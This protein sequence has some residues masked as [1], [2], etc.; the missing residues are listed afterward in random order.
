VPSFDARHAA[1]RSTSSLDNT[2]MDYPNDADGDSLRK[3]VEAGADMS[4][5]MTIDFSVDA[6]D[7][8]A[9]RAIAELV[10]TQGFDPSIS[11]NG[12][13]GSWSVYCSKTMLATY[14]GV[15]A[16]QA[17]LNE[18]S[19]PHGGNCDGWGTFGNSQS[20]T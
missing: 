7:E 15:V 12:G 9:A 1:R 4:R 17:Q 8:H 16:V 19:E 6:P 13:S 18:L 5:P 14:E 2:P 3:V 11:D 20:P 10:S